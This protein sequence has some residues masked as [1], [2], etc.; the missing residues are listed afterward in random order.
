MLQHAILLPEWIDLDAGGSSGDDPLFFD[1]TL[2]GGIPEN[3]ALLYYSGYGRVLWSSVGEKNITVTVSDIDDHSS[4]AARKV[5]VIGVGKIQYNDPVSGF[6]DIAGT[7]YVVTGTTVR[8]KAIPDPSTASWPSSPIW[9]GTSGASGSGVTNDVSFSVLSSNASDYKT[10]TVACGTSAK[11]VNVIVFQFD[12]WVRPDDDFANRDYDRYGVEENVTLSRVVL[13]PNIG[14]SLEW[15]KKSGVGKVEGNRYEAGPIAGSVLLGLR[16]MS[17]PSKGNE[18]TCAKSVIPPSFSFVRHRVQ[19][20][21]YHVQYRHSVI[22]YF[23]EPRNVSFANIKMR[24]GASTPAVCLD[25]FA[26][27]NGEI[28]MPGPWWPVHDHVGQ[29][30]FKWC[31]DTTGIPGETGDVLGQY[32]TWTNYHISIEYM[33]EDS[34]PRFLDSSIESTH[35]LD[36]SGVASTKKGSLPWVSASWDQISSNW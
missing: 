29:D 25:Y 15:Y 35:I 12:T 6:T 33:G 28:H 26:Q 27:Y 10:V 8:F 2:D 7:L 9:N 36:S 22:E 11:T 30:A 16:V 13:P 19:T 34:I 5:M 21:V 32:G 31:D 4:V 23:A 14:V 17:G 1:W 20:G 3:S 24:E 18:K